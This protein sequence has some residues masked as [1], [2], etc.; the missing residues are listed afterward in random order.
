LESLLACPI[1]Y[2]SIGAERQET[3]IR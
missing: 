2:L 3:V 1:K